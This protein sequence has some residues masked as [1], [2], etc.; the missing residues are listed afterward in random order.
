MLKSLKR[1]V[2]PSP[3]SR[4][5]FKVSEQAKKYLIKQKRPVILS[6]QQLKKGSG[7]RDRI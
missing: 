7:Y 5:R 1:A 3:F 6:Y 4:S 2:V